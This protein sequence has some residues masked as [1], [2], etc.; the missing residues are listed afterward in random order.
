M[1][2][3]GRTPASGCGGAGGA[4]VSEVSERRAS[5]VCGARGRRRE[6]AHLKFRL[7]AGALGRPERLRRVRARRRHVRRRRRGRLRLCLPLRRRALRPALRRAAGAAAL[8]RAVHVRRNIL[9]VLEVGAAER[10]RRAR[11]RQVEREHRGVDHEGVR[12]GGRRANRL[13]RGGW[14]RV[15]YMAGRT[16]KLR[17]R[18]RVE[19]G[20]TAVSGTFFFERGA[21]AGAARDSKIAEIID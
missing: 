14:V 1:L 16:A 21:A 6:P 5:V 18:A 10:A 13:R 17:P 20:E 2:L 15:G 11:V 4:A 9:L 3:G 12:H 8:A 7:R 19:S